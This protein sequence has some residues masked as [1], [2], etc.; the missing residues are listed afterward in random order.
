MALSAWHDLNSTSVNSGTLPLDISPC[1]QISF[2]FALEIPYFEILGTADEAVAT[3]TVGATIRVNDPTDTTTLLQWTFTDTYSVSQDLFGFTW[4]S[5]NTSL[6]T[7]SPTPPPQV[8]GSPDGL[9]IPGAGTGASGGTIFSDV[10]ETPIFV[11]TLPQ[12]AIVKIT[13]HTAG[14][15]NLNDIAQLS[16]QTRPAASGVVSG[17]RHASDGHAT[18]LYPRNDGLHQIRAM[19]RSRTLLDDRLLTDTS[20]KAWGVDGTFEIVKAKGG[21]QQAVIYERA[22]G[23]YARISVSD[24]VSYG[25]EMATPYAGKSLLGAERLSSGQT[26]LLMTDSTG[27]AFAGYFARGNTF[28]PVVSATLPAGITLALPGRLIYSGG[29]QVDFFY[30][31]S[32]GLRHIFTTNDGLTWQLSA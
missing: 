31:D 28:S 10:Y 12:G 4:Y 5:L 24:G 14:F 29:A 11:V 23:I 26:L 18:I 30:P 22:G 17:F 27:A 16:V 21:S 3:K 20:G 25:N 15:G 6:T 1:S 19:G 9:C 8:L 32:T 2:R 7:S 13:S